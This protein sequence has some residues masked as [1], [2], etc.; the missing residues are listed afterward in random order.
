MLTGAVLP[1]SGNAWLGGKHI[2]TEQKAVRRL[3]G[4]CPQ[5]DALLDLLTVRE[6]LM[7]FGRLKGVS[8]DRLPNMVKQLME[9]LN[10]S[11]HEHKLSHTLS[12][13]NKRKLSVA[14]ALIGSPPLIFLD[15]PSTGVDPAARRF[16][17]SVISNL[18]TMQKSCSVVLTTHVMEEAEALCGRIG[19]MVGGRLRCL[20]SGQHLKGRFRQ[21]YQLELK[22]RGPSDE[23][24]E[25]LHVKHFKCSAVGL[26][27]P[28]QQ[29][30]AVCDAMGDATR[31]GEIREDGLG[32]VVYHAL[33]QNA[34]GCPATILMEWWLI[35]DTVETVMA[36]IDENFADSVLLER[37][38]LNMRY[39]LSSTTP[40]SSVFR[41]LEAAKDDIA[42]Q[43]YGVCQTSLEQVRVFHRPLLAVLIAFTS[44]QSDD[45]HTWH[46][47]QEQWSSNAC[48]C[49]LHLQIFNS[50]AAQQD[51]ETSAVRGVVQLPSQA[52][53]LQAAE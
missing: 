19:I 10:L 14:I 26:H 13:G 3:I 4:Y 25:A 48:L 50:F 24:I 47:I 12:G 35:T 43:E 21:G 5:H 29:V 2:L 28:A 37:H 18:S 17:W 49:L 39:R 7:F 40:L 30:E 22:L 8:K 51:E 44:S 53:S 38:D 46:G 1:S 32:H 27:V 11:A 33:Q 9:M 42:L 31:Y 36:F 52:G 34:A 16:M 20:G 15:E 23:E 45:P 6:H 41:I